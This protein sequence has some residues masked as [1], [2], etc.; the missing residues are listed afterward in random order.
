MTAIFG[1]SLTT[2]VALTQSPALILAKDVNAIASA[3]V[4]SFLKLVWTKD[5]LTYSFSIKSLYVN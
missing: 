4:W 2:P 5:Q 1:S 3:N